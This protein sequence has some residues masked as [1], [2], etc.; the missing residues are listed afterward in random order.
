MTTRAEHCDDWLSETNEF[1]LRKKVLIVSSVAV[2]THVKEDVKT[3]VRSGCQVR[4]KFYR[5][6]F[7]VLCTVG[8]TDELDGVVDVS[9][10]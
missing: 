9:Y 8:A 6:L 10:Y 7:R 3:S 2:C 5:L 4:H 1:E